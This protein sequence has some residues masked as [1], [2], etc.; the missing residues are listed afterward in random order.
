ME[1]QSSDYFVKIQKQND[2]PTVVKSGLTKEQANKLALQLYHSS[3][4]DATITVEH[5]GRGR[6]S[7]YF[8]YGSKPNSSFESKLDRVFNNIIE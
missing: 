7:T 8:A 2:K 5:M 3:T 4:T 6:I 1:D